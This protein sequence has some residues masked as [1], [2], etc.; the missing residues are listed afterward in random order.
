MYRPA[1]D[2]NYGLRCIPSCST[3]LSSHISPSVCMLETLHR[4]DSLILCEWLSNAWDQSAN[5]EHCTE[6]EH[7]GHGRVGSTGV[8]YMLKAAASP[9]RAMVF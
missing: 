2:L 3:Y 1:D 5:S 8:S 6:R 4:E 9:P 7:A